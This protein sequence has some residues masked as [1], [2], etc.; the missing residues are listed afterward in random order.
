[1]IATKTALRTRVMM[2]VMMQTGVKAK[3]A[4]IDE[5]CRAL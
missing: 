4:T 3:T 1:M 5:R 2:R